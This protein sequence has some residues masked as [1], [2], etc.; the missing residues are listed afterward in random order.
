VFEEEVYRLLKEDGLA[1]ETEGSVE[2]ES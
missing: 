2:Y 1:I